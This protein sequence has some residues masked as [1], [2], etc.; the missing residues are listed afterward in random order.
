[1]KT[2]GDRNHDIYINLDLKKKFKKHYHLDQWPRL[3][4]KRNSTYNDMLPEKP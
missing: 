3:D 2:A 1:M 4:L